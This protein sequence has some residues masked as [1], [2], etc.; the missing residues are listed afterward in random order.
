MKITTETG[1][2]YEISGGF[3]SKN[4][5]PKQKLWWAYCFDWFE[6]MTQED[7]PLPYFE[8]DEQKRLP[9]QVGKRMYIGSRDDSW[10]STTIISIEEGQ[11]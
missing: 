3:W 4:G 6:G 7:V 2:Y 10:V 8:E 9:L 5:G 1:S 11:E